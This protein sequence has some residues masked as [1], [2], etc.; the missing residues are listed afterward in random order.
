MFCAAKLKLKLMTQENKDIMT[1]ISNKEKFSDFSGPIKSFWSINHKKN[2]SYHCVE[3]AS[4]CRS[5]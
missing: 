1:V 3:M 5:W 2:H 4:D